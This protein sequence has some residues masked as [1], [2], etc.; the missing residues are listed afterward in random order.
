MKVS[1][2]E[3]HKTN[4][5]YFSGMKYLKV[6]IMCF[7]LFSCTKEVEI[8]IPHEKPKIVAYS[9]IVPYTPPCP[10]QPGIN[11]QSSM[12]IFDHSSGIINDA[13]VLYFEN[14][15]LKDTLKYIETQ[16][17]Y[18][19]A[20]STSDYPIAGNSYSIRVQKDGY[21]SITASTTIPSKV[22]ISDTSIVPI[23][24][25]DDTGTVYSEISVTFTD[26]ADEI[27]FYEICVSGYAYI[28]ESFNNY[29]ELSTYDNIITSESY[30][31]SILSFDV[32]KPKCLL[33][34]DKSINGSEYTLRVYYCPPQGEG[35]YRCISNHYIS[36]HLRNVSYEYYKFKT[37]MI[38]H[39]NNKEEDI[40]YGMGEPINIISNINNGYGLFAGFNND[41]VSL[42]VPELIIN[43]R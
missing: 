30:Y 18:G 32:N 39:L 22:I 14:G 15:I 21:E 38:Q 40:L 23:S 42:F 16:D 12:H 3:L 28:Y 2:I 26:P 7:L 37:S 5:Y 1:N 27:N 11:L 8:E 10:K 36:V 43:E 41:I 4:N 9:T 33:F 31:P 35:E 19:M 25:F 29:Y 13:I 17:I 20:D 6:I 24:Y 34:N